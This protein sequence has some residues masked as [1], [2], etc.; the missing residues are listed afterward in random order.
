[1]LPALP[2]DLDDRYTLTAEL[3][4]GSHAIVYRALDRHLD[5]EVAVK[6][7]R[8][9]LLGSHVG[10][11]FLREIRL[12]SKLEH[13][14]I[15]HVYGTGE[16]KGSPYFVIALARGA[17]LAERLTH[18]HQLPVAEAL[19]IAKQLAG[20]LQHAHNAGI[21]HRDVKPENILLTPDGALL[22]DFGVA[23]ALSDTPGTLATSTGTAVGTLLYMSPEQLCAEK[24]ID[25][26]S[27][28]YALALVL[29]EMLAGVPAHV[30]ANA[31]G[32]R[33]LRIVG[34]HAPVRAHRPTVPE[35]V[36]EA[37]QQA[38]APSPADRFTS[39][40]G[41]STALDGGPHSAS[42]RVSAATSAVRPVAGP[43][44]TR[45]WL[46]GGVALV[47]VAAGGLGAN[48]F[49]RPA[50]AATVQ[51]A[52]MATR[53]AVVAEGDSAVAHALATELGLWSAEIRAAVSPS[54]GAE[55]GVVLTTRV[56]PLPGGVNASVQIR[57][58]GASASAPARVVQVTLPSDAALRADS[59]RLLAAR[60]LMATQVSPDSVELPDVVVEHPVAALRRYGDGW[61]ALL[62]GELAQ[63]ERAFTDASR[64]G[65]LPQAALW[66]ATVASWRQPRAPAAWRDAADAARSVVAV[67]PRRDSLLAEALL[68]RASD[69]MPESCEAYSRATRI[70]GGSFAAWYGL[71]EC[72][73]LDSIVVL[74]EAS[75]TGARFRTSRWGAETAFEEA[76]ERLPAAGLVPLFERLPAI[77]LALNGAKRNG[78][79]LRTG[80][81]NYAGLPALSGDTVVVWPSPQLAADAAL[82]VP[83]TYQAAV[84]RLRTRLLDLTQSLSRRAPQSIAAQLAYAGALEYAG[85][86]R[87]SSGPSAL[88]VLDASLAVARSPSDSASIRIAILR[89]HLRLAD[90]ASASAV[91]SQLLR[92]ADRATAGDAERLAPVAL[93]VGRIALAESL[94]VHAI[95]VSPEN[96]DGLPP[97]VATAVAQFRVAS[98]L[99]ACESVGKLRAA[100]VDGLRKHFAQSERTAAE[101]Q[102]LQSAD[103]SR[104][105]CAGAPTPQDAPATDPLVRA[106]QSLQRSDTAAAARILQ[107]MRDGRGG[108]SAGSV[109]WDTRFAEMS[110]TLQA[111]DTA[112][113]VTTLVAVL[114]GFDATMDYALRDLEQSAGLRRSLALCDSLRSRIPTLQRAGA[115][116]HAAQIHLEAGKSR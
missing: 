14:H 49:R 16:F 75:P 69:R 53:F 42:F 103:W 50:A 102:W 33:G 31:E 17:T 82:T 55:S 20:A 11:R 58:A 41:F 34:K 39:I 27:D 111:R 97:A 48:R 57:S 21:I 59:L 72:L 1:M 65:S 89:Q 24:D 88:S 66:R 83:S 9:E 77:T 43:L 54:E 37:L 101:A 84:R 10:E 85:V 8:E 81:K 70:A 60:V 61:V 30:A 68:H 19:T 79:W 113:A 116:C 36:E 22:T 93:L 32:L 114:E 29:Y 94:M 12:T 52:S 106:R 44:R 18:E 92:N 47:A 45:R 56:T 98:A 4:R 15:A 7:L 6:M 73:R 3:G 99:G 112:G 78:R 104:L 51:P 26:R 95:E 2:C 90:F 107:L 109:A 76:I 80:G 5:R 108:A 105:T 86:L 25:A 38:L 28:Q 87:A 110:M 67:L 100:A 71:G 91:S 46:V 40:S 23:R 63:A 74:D 62:A 115:V 96:G 64:S 35:H 13:P